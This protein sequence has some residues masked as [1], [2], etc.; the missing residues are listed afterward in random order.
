[1][2]KFFAKLCSYFNGLKDGVLLMLVPIS[3]IIGAIGIIVA[4]IRNESMRNYIN[5]LASDCDDRKP[6]RYSDYA[7]PDKKHKTK[8]GFSID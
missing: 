7:K 5:E 8:M 1:M 2:C 4:I 3:A 6:V